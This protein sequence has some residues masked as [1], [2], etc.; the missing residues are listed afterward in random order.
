MNGKQPIEVGDILTFGDDP[1]LW[2][3]AELKQNPDT[4]AIIGGQ[5][6]LAKQE[7]RRVPKRRI[8]RHPSEK[9]KT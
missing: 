9:V 5:L 4:G 7:K 1:L 2:R 6:E 8:N 3:V